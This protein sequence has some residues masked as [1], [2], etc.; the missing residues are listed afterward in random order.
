MDQLDQHGTGRGTLAVWVRGYAG[1]TVARRS[2]SQGAA[3]ALAR[4]IEL[5]REAREEREK[6]ERLEALGAA[7]EP[8]PVPPRYVAEMRHALH[9]AR[10]G[11][12]PWNEV[13]LNEHRLAECYGAALSLGW[14]RE[15]GGTVVLGGLEFIPE[16]LRP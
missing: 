1:R 6:A 10:A 7:M 5:E 12:R 3:K 13:G 11:C 8:P 14:V 4:A 2:Y 15:V 16:Y 9:C